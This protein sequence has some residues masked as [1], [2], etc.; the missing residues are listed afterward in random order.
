MAP[1]PSSPRHGILT[2]AAGGLGRAL[3]VRLARDGWRLALTDQDEVGLAET[4]E[5]VE[6]AGGHGECELLDVTDPVAWRQLRDRL[7]DRWPRLDLLVNNAGV[8]GAGAVGE[9][10]PEDWQWILDTNL[11]GPIYGCHTMVPWMTEQPGTAYV[12]NIASVAG[13]IAPPTM[14]AYNVAKA[15]LIALSETLYNELHPRGFGVTVVCPGFFQSNLIPSGRFSNERSR[16][17][18]KEFNATA[19]ITA[20]W[21]ADRAIRAMYRR[22]LYVVDGLR[23]RLLWRIKRMMPGAFHR[24]LSSWI[25]R[26]DRQL[27]EQSPTKTFSRRP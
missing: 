16:Q 17:Q 7:Q 8:C 13:L 25:A 21:V 20:T 4:L 2:G 5:L 14:G 22:K 19:R 27:G 24:L 10:A 23:A 9:F 1:S 12:L 26:V 3:A 15:G 11:Q 6:A 18:A